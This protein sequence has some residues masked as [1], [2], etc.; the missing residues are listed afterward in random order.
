MVVVQGHYP[1]LSD[2]LRCMWLNKKIKR[3]DIIRGGEGRARK[4]DG[5]TDR[6]KQRETDK[7]RNRQDR[8]YPF[9]AIYKQPVVERVC[10]MHSVGRVNIIIA[11]VS[12][13]DRLVTRLLST[14]LL[15]HALSHP[16]T[17]QMYAQTD[18]EKVAQKNKNTLDWLF[19]QR[20]TESPLMYV[21]L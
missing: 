6:P 15:I 17:L 7:E 16:W 1:L 12:A 10:T 14:P 21:P 3:I 9:G 4:K 19:W 20:M 13:T 11:F 8:L 18:S 2:V 5:R